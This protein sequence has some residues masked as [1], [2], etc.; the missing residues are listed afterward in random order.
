MRERK[1]FTLAELLVTM[2]IGILVLGGVLLSLIQSMILSE[3][4]EKFAIAM[5]IARTKIESIYSIRSSNFGSIVD[6][7]DDASARL[8]VA[9]DGIDGRY[10]IEVD[11]VP[12]IGGVAEELKEVKVKVCWKGRAGK[13]VGDCNAALTSWIFPYSSPCTITAAVA[14]R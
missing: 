5:N 6:S 7:A 12:G 3:Y 1:A 14:K 9:N 13:I 2:A 11:D 4:N 8:T 10:R